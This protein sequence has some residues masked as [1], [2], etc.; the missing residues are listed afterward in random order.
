M[1]WCKNILKYYINISHLYRSWNAVFAMT[2]LEYR[3]TR[4]HDFYSV[5]TLFAIPVYCDFQA[6][7][8][9][10]ALSIVLSTDNPQI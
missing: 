9:H 2:S 10:K 5:A 3:V 4:Y 8:L 7:V 6:R 1:I